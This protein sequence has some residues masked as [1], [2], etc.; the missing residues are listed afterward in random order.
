MKKG[1]FPSASPPT[2]FSLKRHYKRKA[3]ETSHKK[4]SEG[5][6][7]D[8]EMEASKTNQTRWECMTPQHFHTIPN[9]KKC[10]RRKH[11]VTVARWGH[12]HFEFH[13]LKFLL[14]KSHISPVQIS[15]PAFQISH[16]SNAHAHE[17]RFEHA[18]SWS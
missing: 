1:I 13:T 11:V 15:N 6:Q 4:F 17:L 10:E 14:C 18:S 12:S 16:L 5:N 9:K 8:V 3:T 2:F 7:V